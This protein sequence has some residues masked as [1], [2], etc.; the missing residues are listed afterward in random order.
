ML[1]CGVFGNIADADVRGAVEALPG[2]CASGGVV[3]WTRHRKPPDLTPRI[4]A[5]F[6][7]AGF[8]ELAYDAPAGTSS[9]I[10]SHRLVG[11]AAP[12]TPGRRLFTFTR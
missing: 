10:G 1:V 8:A 9:G 3:V 2:L 5:W 12:L 11:A 4:R 6:A 7:A